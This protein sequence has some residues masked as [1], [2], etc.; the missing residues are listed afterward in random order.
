MTPVNVSEAYLYYAPFYRYK[1]YCRQK[2]KIVEPCRDLSRVNY[3][4]WDST[5][6]GTAPQAGQHRKRDSTIRSFSVLKH[7][8]N[9]KFLNDGWYNFS[10]VPSLAR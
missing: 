4:K 9:N 3:R 1:F 8:I 5:A 6:S 7:F 2:Y 10:V